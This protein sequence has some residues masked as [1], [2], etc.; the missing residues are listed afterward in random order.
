MGFI[1]QARRA[2]RLPFPESRYSIGVQVLSSPTTL[3]E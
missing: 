1:R 2:A 3:R